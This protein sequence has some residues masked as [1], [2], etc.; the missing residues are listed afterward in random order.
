MLAADYDLLLSIFP[1]EKAW[2][3]G[4]VPRLRV[5]FIGHPMLDRIRKSETGNRKPKESPILLLLPG[6]RRSELQKHLPVMIPAAKLIRAKVPDAKIKMV[7]P[8]KEL[9]RLAASLGV[10]F[11]IQIGSLPNALAQ[12]DV[13][14]AS[15]GTVTMECAFF[16]VPAVTLYKTSWLTYEIGRRIVTV[17]SLTMP[18][19]LAG[20]EVLSRIHPRRRHSPTHRQRRARPSPKSNP[21]PEN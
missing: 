21:S 13:A 6:S 1:F 5:E 15:T 9:A 16:G 17:N 19:L 8:N 4:R 11:S 18:N 2:Y 12:T 3:A 14:I 20:E 7:A 10:N